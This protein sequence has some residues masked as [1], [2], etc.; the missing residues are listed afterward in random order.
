MPD[1]SKNTQAI[2]LLTAP[3]IT[4]PRTAVPG[5][6]SPGEYKRLARNLREINCEPADLLS[7]DGP[8]LRGSQAVVDE[9]RLRGLLGRGFLLSQAVERW[10]SRAIWV[11]SRADFDYPRRLKA[12]LRED[13]PPVIYGCGDFNLAE[14]GGLAVVGSRNVSDELIDYT[15]DVGRL[16]AQARR[17]VV[18]GGAKGIDQ[19]AM[20]GAIEG[21]GRVVGVL[22]DSLEKTA[23]NRENR[24]LLI[25]G[26]LLLLSPYDPNAGFNVGNAMQRN[27]LIFALADAGLIVSADLNKGGT[28]AG[29]TQQ[30]E[31]LRLVPLFVRSTGPASSGLDALKVKGAMLW[32]NPT[33]ATEFDD[34]VKVGMLAR[35]SQRQPETDLFTY[36]SARAEVSRPRVGEGSVVVKETPTS[37]AKAVS[38][39]SKKKSWRAKGPAAS[40]ADDLFS[41]VRQIIH[42]LLTVPMKEV[43]V[44]DSLNV[45]IAQARSWLNRLVEERVLEKSAKPAKYVASSNSELFKS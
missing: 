39:A 5:L 23:M 40:V 11:V 42:E 22:A 30:L 38:E 21:G 31:K 27:K 33:D 12:R 41:A 8:A 3:L 34:A 43:E 45:S 7:S 24:N 10:R 13:S 19:A 6:L 35:K 28:W 20:R 14:S 36:D 25:D 26:Q 32:P 37:S 18:S 15:R 44:A 4:G 2:L 29:A 16:A 9:N 1:I 17:T